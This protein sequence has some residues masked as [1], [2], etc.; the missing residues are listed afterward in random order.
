[1]VATLQR[2]LQ[3]PTTTAAPTLRRLLGQPERIFSG[4]PIS[5]IFDVLQAGQFAAAGLATG[6]GIA[7]GIAERTSYGE[8]LSPE[9]RRTIPGRAVELGLNIFGDPLT[10][11][12]VGGLAVKGARLLPG[13]ARALAAVRAPFSAAAV[14]AGLAIPKTVRAARAVE[15]LAETSLEPLRGVLRGVRSEAAIA[16]IEAAKFSREFRR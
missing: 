16:R 9:F 6:K 5:D 15:G 11:V 14:R 12:P 4:G 10:Y 7:R 1:M 3:P 13:G 8:L 2:L